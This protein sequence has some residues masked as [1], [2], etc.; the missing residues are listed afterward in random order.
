MLKPLAAAL[1]GWAPSGQVPDVDPVVLLAAGWREIAGEDIARHSAPARI[2]DETLFVATASSGWSH[3]LSFLSEKIL[4]AVRARFPHTAVRQLRFRVGTLPERPGRPAPA[5]RQ[6]ASQE[7]APERPPAATLEEAL[8]RFRTGVEA[9]RRANAARGWKECLACGASIAPG[10]G[11]LCVACTNAR[12]QRRS[13]EIARLLFEAPWLGYDGTA[14]LVE[15][16]TRPEY[17]SVR[18]ALLSRWWETLS[19]AATAKKLSRDGRERSIA[20][21]YV[22][23]RTKLAPEEIRPATVRNVLGDEIHDLIYGTETQN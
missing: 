4:A 10:E 15:G 11:S 17:E 20:S 1:G 12:R 2:A 22:L 16:T 6:R 7:A 21:S 8:G 5:A 3:E 13:G 9:R 19:K 18:A 14:A 23:L